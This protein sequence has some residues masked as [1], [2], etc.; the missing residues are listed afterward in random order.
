MVPRVRDALTEGGYGTLEEVTARNTYT[1][2][3]RVRGS[4][5]RISVYAQVEA[6]ICARIP[7]ENN[8]RDSSMRTS[9]IRYINDYYGFN[10]NVLKEHAN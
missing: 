2:M 7:Q 10:E 1:Y 9:D 8:Q 5:T 4:P 6:C 3:L